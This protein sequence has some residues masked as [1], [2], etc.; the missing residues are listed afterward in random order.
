MYTNKI[1]TWT[2]ICLVVSITICYGRWIQDDS[3]AFESMEERNQIDKLS[4][5]FD[6]NRR[7]VQHPR[8]VLR[9]QNYGTNTIGYL[10]TSYYCCAD[11]SR[12]DNMKDF[13][14]FNM[15][16]GGCTC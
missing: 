10:T 15:K 6:L 8:G 13:C 9:C 5:L 4:E 7:H 11:S 14:D 16:Q 3:D 1:L 12:R 2:I